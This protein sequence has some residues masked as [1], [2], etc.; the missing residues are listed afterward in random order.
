MVPVPIRCLIPE[1]LEKIGKNQQW[2]AD[3]SS[4]SKSQMSDYIKMR[5]KVVLGLAKAKQI[6]KLLKLKSAEDLYLWDW[7]EE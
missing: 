4:I 7:R 2:L 6:A 3:Q 1:H 5:R